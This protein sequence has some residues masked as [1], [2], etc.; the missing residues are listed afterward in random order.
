MVNTIISYINITKWTDT[1]KRIPS[2][3]YFKYL[4]VVT[5]K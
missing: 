5:D 3:F 4:L 2:V 1:E